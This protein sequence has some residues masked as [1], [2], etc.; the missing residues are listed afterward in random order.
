MKLS[1]H[2]HSTNPGLYILGHSML[3]MWTKRWIA[4]QLI[5]FMYAAL[6]LAYRA[7]YFSLPL[8]E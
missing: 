8:D 4:I 1:A 2:M 7:I 3:L 5:R 6:L